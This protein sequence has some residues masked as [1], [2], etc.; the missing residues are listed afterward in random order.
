M[1]TKTFTPTPQEIKHEWYIVDA[2]G[3]TLGRVASEVA[4]LLKGKH[5][6]IYATHMD[7]GDYV[8][9]IN[10]KDIVVTGNKLADK[11]YVH[12]TMYPGGFREI[13][14]QDQLAKHP[15]RP[16][17]DAVKG[18]LPRNRLG[19]AMLSK[20]KVY[21]GAEHPHGAQQPKEY[22]LEYTSAREG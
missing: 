9:V 22:K 19:N 5:K 13:N 4:K 17:Y 21:A 7:T 8:I 1:T 10:A 6:P 3:M 12:H 18:M 20:L 2:A 16:V 14:L 15:T 11:K